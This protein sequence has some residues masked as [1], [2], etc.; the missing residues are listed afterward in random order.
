MSNYEI[1]TDVF[2]LPYK[3]DQCILYAP[4]RG[5]AC[6]ANKELV[7]FILGLEG[8]DEPALES[9]QKGILDLLVEKG[10][11]NGT[12]KT[13]PSGESSQ[14]IAPSKLTLFPTNRCN[15]RCRYCY[16]SNSRG[17]ETTMDREI[18][19]SAIDYHLSVLKE[20]GR[21]VFLLEFHGGGEPFCA[22]HLVQGIVQYARRRCTEEGIELHVV[23]GT[24]GV[25]SKTKLSWVIKHFTFL[26][27]SFEGLPHVQD[28][29]RP[30]ANGGSSFGHVDETIGFLDE[31]NFPYALR[32]TVSSYNEK[33]LAETIEFIASRYKTKLL[34]LE[35][36]FA[37]GRFTLDERISGPDMYAFADTFMGKGDTAGIFRCEP[38]PAVTE[39][40]LRGN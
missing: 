8:M 12:E 23:A 9:R 3:G 40:L 29:H 24:N 6:L 15:M 18:A 36:M 35:P 37:C 11:L 25:L 38:R 10:V 33:L 5:F 26:N 7:D 28:F 4:T 34:F 19:T 27:V 2:S 21:T 31:H 17:A 16:A 30:M 14:T 13:I 22:W 32:C 39:F 20:Q 1:T